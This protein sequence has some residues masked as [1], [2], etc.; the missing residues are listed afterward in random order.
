[1][2]SRRVLRRVLGGLIHLRTGNRETV[3]KTKITGNRETV[4]KTKGKEKEKGK[5][6]GK[7]KV[8]GKRTRKKVKGKR[9]VK[10]KKSH[11]AKE[12]SLGGVKAVRAAVLT[13]AVTVI[14]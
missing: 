10:W 9:K 13:R 12:A 11:E 3:T 2:V 5:G 6:K 4:T 1:M 8:K 14:V 7:R